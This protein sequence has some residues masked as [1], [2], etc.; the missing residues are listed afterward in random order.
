M[1][2]SI[3]LIKYG[4]MR[5]KNMLPEEVLQ[6]LFNADR[7]AIQVVMQQKGEY[8][9]NV[10]DYGYINLIKLKELFLR[11][12]FDAFFVDQNLVIKNYF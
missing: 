9:L 2:R 4:S 7:I 12:G 6:H 11:A 1:K 8:T 10:G 3:V 5:G